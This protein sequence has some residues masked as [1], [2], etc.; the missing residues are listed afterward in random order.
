MFDSLRSSEIYEV[1]LGTGHCLFFVDLYQSESAD[2][3]RSAT[4][5]I[6]VGGC[7]FTTALSLFHGLEHLLW[8]GYKFLSSFYEELSQTILAKLQRCR[9]IL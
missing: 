4:V 6:H 8:T 2:K 9:L 3:M 5:V 7:S 1:E